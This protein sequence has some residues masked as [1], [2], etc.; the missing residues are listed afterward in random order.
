MCHLWHNSKKKTVVIDRRTDKELQHFP[1]A[2]QVKFKGLFKA[3][4]IY[5]K[6][7]EPEGKKLVGNSGLFEIRVKHQGQWRA[8]Y[9]YIKNDQ[10][11]VLCAFVKK[12]Q[13]TSKSELDKA[14]YRLLDYL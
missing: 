2:V 3:L 9:A 10:I 7:E 13:K 14:K 12:T 1:V 8:V 4:G 5:G 6:L 11:I